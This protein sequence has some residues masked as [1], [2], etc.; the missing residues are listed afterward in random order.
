M[1]DRVSIPEDNGV[2]LNDHGVTALSKSVGQGLN[3]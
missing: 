1:L 2:D 3:I